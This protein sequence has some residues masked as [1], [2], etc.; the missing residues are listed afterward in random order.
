MSQVR[1]EG[2]GAGTGLPGFPQGVGVRGGKEAQCLSSAVQLCL[3]QGGASP[4]LLLSPPSLSGRGLATWEG[5]WACPPLCPRG[6]QGITT[7]DPLL[8]V[9]G[10]EGKAKEWAWVG[11]WEEV[12]PPLQIASSPGGLFAD[13]FLALTHYRIYF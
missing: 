13:L 6:S 3:E 5:M 8:S 1:H 11:R 9:R 2:R 7:P 4:P 12:V 10:S